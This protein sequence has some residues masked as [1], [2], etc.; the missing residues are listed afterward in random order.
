[1]KG[2]RDMVVLEKVRP[3][4]LV[5][6]LP[7][8]NVCTHTNAE[9]GTHS[10]TQDVAQALMLVQND[11][12]L[13]PFDAKTDAYVQLALGTVQSRPGPVPG[14]RAAIVCGD[15][16][17]ERDLSGSSFRSAI[18]RN[19]SIG[20]TLGSPRFIYFGLRLGKMTMA[21]LQ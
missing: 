5:S 2:I 7:M 3:I 21:P 14:Y 18:A 16:E 9:L 11:L 10:P 6:S 1:M 13:L 12:S 15:G 19:G 4:N 17:G 8:L 20:A